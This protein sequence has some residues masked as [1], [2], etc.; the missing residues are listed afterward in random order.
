MLPFSI[1]SPLC[2]IF[3]HG[4]KGSWKKWRSSFENGG[5]GVVCLVSPILCVCVIFAITITSNKRA[6][7]GSTRV[8][9][10]LQ[11]NAL[12]VY[13]FVVFVAGIIF[14]NGGTNYLRFL[15]FFI[16]KFSNRDPL[17][18]FHQLT[19]DQ[20]NRGQ[21]LKLLQL[22]L[23]CFSIT[24][25]SLNEMWWLLILNNKIDSFIKQKSSVIEPSLP[26]LLLYLT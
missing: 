23:L 19:R 14:V 12:F 17:C 13:L 26:P 22:D 6:T 3:I 5:S 21:I 9:F 16:E 11:I 10:V 7:K 25:H 4:K 15:F 20:Y 24:F 18:L 2:S 1:N 8:N